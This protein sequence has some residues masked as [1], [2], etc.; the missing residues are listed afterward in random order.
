M[1]ILE[2]AI[3]EYGEAIDDQVIKVDAFI[4][5][6]VD[7]VLM[8]QFAEAI[9][10]HFKQHKITKVLTIE[11][12][13]IAPALLCAL[14]LKVPMVFLKKQ[15]PS[16]L[17][18]VYSAEVFSFTKQKNYTLMLDQQYL[19][20][21]DQVL[22]VDDFLANGAACKGAIAI[23]QQAHAKLSGIAIL[24]EKSFQDGRALLEEQGYE[25]YS[26]ARIQKL[27]K[28]NITFLTGK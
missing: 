9:V 13:G 4:N 27:E 7:P 2:S 16:T 8:D 23:I 21:S 15:K 20:E 3:L 12:S 11:A 25:V 26:L 10:A 5:Q 22:F 1:N 24:I 6:Q 18:D 14:K 17:K 19:N 28:G